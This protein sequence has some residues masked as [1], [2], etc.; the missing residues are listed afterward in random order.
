M[1]IAKTGAS[2]KGGI[3]VKVS[4]FSRRILSGLAAAVIFGSLPAFSCASAAKNADIPEYYPIDISGIDIPSYSSYYDKHSGSKIPAESIV[5]RG[6][7]YDTAKYGT[8]GTGSF[9]GGDELRSGVLSW[10][11]PEEKYPIAYMFPKQGCIP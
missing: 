6:K 5:I 7:D 10:E 11:S 3:T 1:H 8:F 2:K 4:A 9:T